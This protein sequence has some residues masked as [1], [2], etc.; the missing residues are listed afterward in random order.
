MSKRSQL[1][2]KGYKTY[3]NDEIYVFW[4]PE[5]CQHAQE[6]IKGNKDVFD[7]TRRPWVDVNAAPASKIAEIIDRCPSGA[8]LYELLEK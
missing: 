4:N 8:L 2:S 6:C 7:V 1:E 3:E 5:L